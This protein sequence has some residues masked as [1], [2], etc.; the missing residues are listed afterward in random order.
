MSGDENTIT[1][2]VDARDVSLGGLSFLTPVELEINSLVV[3]RIVVK[4]RVYRLRARI[5]YCRSDRPGLF[6]S[7]AIFSNGPTQFR[8]RLARV[9]VE[10]YE[11]HLALLRSDPAITEEA[12]ADR[13]LAEHSF[14]EAA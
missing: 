3:L 12:A 7:G 10:I 13:W 5:A 9:F 8:L 14:R 11:Y 1:L 6:Q 4:N 2:N